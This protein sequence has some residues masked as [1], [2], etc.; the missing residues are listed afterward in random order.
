MT[1]TYTYTK[2]LT[3]FKA[4]HLKRHISSVQGKPDLRY[5]EV[6]VFE[7]RTLIWM[8]E[9]ILT[10]PTARATVVDCFVEN[11]E[12]TFNH[13][14][15]VA[16][17]RPKLDIIKNFSNIALHQLPMNFY[18]IIYV[19]GSHS[20]V[21]VISDCIQAWLLL[22]EDGFMVLDDYLYHVDGRPDK[23][24]PKFAIDVFLQLYSY[25]IELLYSGFEIILKKKTAN[26][27][28]FT[29]L[30]GDNAFYCW[31]THKLYQRDSMDTI[32]LTKEEHEEL[33]KYLFNSE[34][35][36]FRTLQAGPSKTVE[37]VLQTVPAPATGIRLKKVVAVSRLRRFY[38]Y[39]KSKLKRMLIFLRRIFGF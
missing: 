37:K 38:D 12:K 31:G 29:S 33:K 7:G 28:R 8:F 30:I 25:D 20:S 13:N 21:D 19:D 22:K 2:D 39:Q 27:P 15:D 24:Q 3:T 34:S 4:E 14:I 23:H 35:Y 17:I 26:N 10:H 32:P 11:T 9:N 36:S 1:K 6:G 5:L 16:G 18:D